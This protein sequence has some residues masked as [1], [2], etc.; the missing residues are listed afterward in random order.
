MHDCKQPLWP[1]FE[2]LYR[3]S[4]YMRYMGSGSIVR[5]ELAHLV[6]FAFGAGT[7][8]QQITLYA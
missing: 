8:Q 2:A 3:K 1:G 7:R 5:D 4:Q 6:N